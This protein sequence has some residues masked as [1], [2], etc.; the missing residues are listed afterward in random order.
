MK[1]EDKKSLRQKTKPELK[2]E[3]EKTEKDL[4]EAKIKK[5]KGQLN[6][7]SLP[8]QLRNK[9]AVIKTIINEKENS[10]K[11]EENNE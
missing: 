9:I 7:V 1:K 3:L 8:A 11:E 6:N 4:V 2:A 5:S 10:E